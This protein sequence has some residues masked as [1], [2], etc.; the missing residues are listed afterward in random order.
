MYTLLDTEQRE[1]GWESAVELGILLH[2][3]YIHTRFCKMDRKGA[4]PID[5][6]TIWVK[7]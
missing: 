1:N 4:N 3:S 6:N 2:Y 5:F 7:H